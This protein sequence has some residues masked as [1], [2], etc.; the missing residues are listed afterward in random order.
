MD[1]VLNRRIL[2]SAGRSIVPPHPNIKELT[3]R[4]YVNTDQVL[5]NQSIM[6]K[7]IDDTVSIVPCPKISENSSKALKKL[8]SHYSLNEARAVTPTGSIHS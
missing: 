6:I 8:D 7:F 5:F 2:G 1:I 4:I 3:D